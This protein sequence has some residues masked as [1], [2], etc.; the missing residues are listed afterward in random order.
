MPLYYGLVDQ[1]N[2]ELV[3]AKLAERVKKD[4]YKIK[5]GEIGLKP[6]FMSLAKYGYNDIVYQMANQTDCPSYGYWVKQGYTTTPEYWDVGA[7]SQNHCMM[8]HIEEWFFSQLGGIRNEGN[9]FDVI[10]IEPW[11]PEDMDHLDVTTR[12]IYGNI[13]CHYERGVDNEMN[14]TFEIPANSQANIVLPCLN[15]QSVF[16]NGKD[17]KNG[18]K[19]VVS[20]EYKDGK[21]YL[22]MGSGNYTLQIKKKRS[23]RNPR[24]KHLKGTAK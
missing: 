9:A 15:H 19:G 8:D 16:E 23:Y 12:S 2:E 3:A 4:N 6:L 22:K 7:F 18:E 1:E 11:I 14:Y 24:G 13:R 21:A 10:R 20:V 17:V 5:T